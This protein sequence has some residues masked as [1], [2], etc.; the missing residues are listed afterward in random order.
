MEDILISRIGEFLIEQLRG[1]LKR[2]GHN[3][4]GSLAKSIEYKVQ[5]GADK[6]TIDFLFNSYGEALNT[7][8]KASRIPYSP[9]RRTGAKSS[10]YIT[11][12]IRW[13]KLKFGYSRQRAER[14]A[15]AIASRHSREGMPLT[16][17]IGWVDITLK[18]TKD[19]IERIVDTWVTQVLNDL[20]DDFIKSL[21]NG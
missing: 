15:F 12:L 10:K 9:L 2:Q 13:V 18:S 5:E 14:A 3:L 11:G 7:G 16:G 21:N 17:K 8:V 19:E 20:L 6:L 4:T 1:E